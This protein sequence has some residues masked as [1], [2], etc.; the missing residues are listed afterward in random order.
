MIIPTKKV[1]IKSPDES[2]IICRKCDQQALCNKYNCYKEK[3]NIMNCTICDERLCQYHWR[4][5]FRKNVKC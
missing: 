5:Y 4:I 1:I 2:E 3:Q